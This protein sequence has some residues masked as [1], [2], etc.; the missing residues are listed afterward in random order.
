MI[1]VEALTKTYGTRRAVDDLSFT[2]ERGRVTGFVGPNGSGKATTMRM[3]VN[4][5][6]SDTGA[7][8]YYG[9]PCKELPQPART[10]GVAVDAARLG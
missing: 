9:V 1:T 10:I 7:V 2:V 8:T 4:I 5:T 6:R 3:V